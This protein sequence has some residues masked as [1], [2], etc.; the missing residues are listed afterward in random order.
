MSREEELKREEELQKERYAQYLAEEKT[1]FDSLMSNDV[2]LNKS[3]RYFSGVILILLTSY[4]REIDH[5]TWIMLISYAPFILSIIT[6]VI[7]YLFIQKALHKQREFNEQYYLQNIESAATQ[8]SMENKIGSFLT[9]TSII[10]FVVGI[11]I[12]SALMILGMLD[13]KG[14][15]QNGS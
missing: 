14:G 1:I 8:R 11:L 13:V 15:E 9:F 2:E 3:M 4:I 12:I 10:L 7:S 5:K 6:G